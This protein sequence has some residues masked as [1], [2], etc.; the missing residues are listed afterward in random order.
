MVS[1]PALLSDATDRLDDL[2]WLATVPLVLGLVALNNFEQL[3]RSNGTNFGVSFGVPVPV[4]T[5][6]SFVSLPNEAQG[7]TVETGSLATFV[8]FT[9]LFLLGS[10]ILGAGYLGSIDRIL[11]GRRVDFL[12]DV[13]RYLA[14]FVG[15]GLLVLA[16]VLVT[17][18]LVLVSVPLA[19]L[20]FLLFFVGAYLLWAAPYLVVVADLDL[21]TSLS[22]SYE[23]AVDGGRYASYFVQYLLAVAVIS[24][25][26]TPVF[27]NAGVA[28]G[29]AG[30]VLLTPLGLVFDTA[31][32]SFVR[33]LVD[34][35]GVEESGD[36]D[37]REG[38]AGDG[39]AGDGDDGDGDDGWG[40]D[41]V[42]DERAGTQSNIPV[43]M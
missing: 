37:H 26:A 42:T 9:A 18:G 17:A 4:T 8:P 34:G 6:W 30:V 14:P 38:D 29:L 15:F 28:G 10:A 39:D 43:D 24:L 12:A 11:D 1:L 22:R 40:I 31:T 3:A 20:A 21:G 35:D 33:D 23:Y 5:A 13:A 36:T 2:L 19:L 32:T 7:V 25:V 16:A 27:T 41:G